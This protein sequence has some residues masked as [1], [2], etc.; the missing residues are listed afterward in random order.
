MAQRPV[1]LIV[2]GGYVGLYTALRLQKRLTRKQADI[3]VVDPQPHMTYQPF[4][5]EAAAGSVEPRHVVVPLRRVLPRCRVITGA[6]TG[7]NHAQRR[8]QIAPMEGDAFELSYD[9]LV[10][11]AGSVAR[12]LPIPGLAEHGIGFKTIGEAI[13]LRNHVLARLDAASSTDDPAVRQRALTFT[14]IGGG[15][16]GIEALAETED[17][18]RYAIEHYHPRLSSADMRWVLVEASGR[19]LPEVD[20]DLAAWTVRQLTKRGI[21]VRLNTRLESISEDGVVRL[22]DGDQFASETLVW[23]AGTK[24]NPLVA[25][26]DLPLDDRG[27]VRCKPTLQVQDVADAWA[28]GDLAAVPDLTKPGATT[29]PN[30][31][32][33]VRQ[34]K[35]LADNIVATLNGCEPVAYRH[36]YVGSVASLGL[37]KGVAQ[38]YGLKLRGWPA[39]LM[40]RAYHVSR[41]PT[42]DRKVRI[43]ADWVLSSLFRREVIALGQVQDPWRD[44]V[45]AAGGG[46]S[47]RRLPRVPGPPATGSRQGEAAAS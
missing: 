40:H 43:V 35:R 38:V 13:Y 11:A 29:A 12:T 37:H 32:H 27:R 20:A 7:L 14:F 3:V 42:L 5:P 36:R 33:A 39:W 9:I 28:A 1:I 21:D 44:F 15:Y 25:H 4:L 30:A 17:M 10:M 8:A 24:P 23:T 6:V 18:A 41:M 2:G 26:T 22:S 46:D 45:A 47:H 34:A 31:Q 19:I 16:A